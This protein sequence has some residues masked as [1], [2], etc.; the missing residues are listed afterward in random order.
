MFGNDVLKKKFKRD[1]KIG[2]N[3]FKNYFLSAGPGEIGKR[4]RAWAAVVVRSNL[5]RQKSILVKADLLMNSGYSSNDIRT[6]SRGNSINGSSFTPPLSVLFDNLLPFL[7][8]KDRP[9][10]DKVLSDLIK[11]GNFHVGANW[12]IE[13]ANNTLYD[14]AANAVRF[15]MRTSPPGF[16]IKRYID[17][18]FDDPSYPLL[19]IE[20]KSVLPSNA[21]TASNLAQFEYDL[22]R[23]ESL[24]E[25]RWIF[26]GRKLPNGLDF[27][28][29]ID[30][31]SV[32]QVTINKLLGR[33]GTIEELKN[34]IYQKRDEIFSIFVY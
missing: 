32:N 24:D 15:E 9:G 34:L 18:V 2:D 25:L 11:G 27:G 29:F 13:V 17:I 12:T 30:S 16:P 6:I 5:R 21:F 26:D 28:I 7:K 4:V 19:Y 10:F 3:E 1:F 8:Y 22:R 31:I 20:C 14:A 23:I 33:S